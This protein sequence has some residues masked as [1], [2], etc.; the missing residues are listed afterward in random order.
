MSVEGRERERERERPD[1][2]CCCNSKGSNC[3][4]GGG[5]GDKTNR[6][7]GFGTHPV[8]PVFPVRRG[9]FASSSATT[10]SISVSL[11]Q[12][13][14]LKFSHISLTP[15]FFLLSV[16]VDCVMYTVNY[17]TLCFIRQ[18]FGAFFFVQKK[19]ENSFSSAGIPVCSYP[20]CVKKKE[21]KKEK[22]SINE[23]TRA[24]AASSSH[25]LNPFVPPVRL[26][27]TS[28]SEPPACPYGTSS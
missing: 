7:S 27:R 26:H 20:L 17:F 22:R 9:I 16:F 18:R 10:S 14:L 23:D 6:P 8:W 2:F 1:R 25:T 13:N 4:I 3:V 24:A 15:Y 12:T 11:P 28:F 5:G 21:R 19:C